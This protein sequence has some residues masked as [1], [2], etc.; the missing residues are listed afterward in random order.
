MNEPLSISSGRNLELTKQGREVF[1]RPRLL[2][3]TWT[4][5][6]E[7]SNQI[8]GVGPRQHV[9][10]ACLQLSKRLDPAAAIIACQP[11]FKCHYTIVVVDLRGI[12][13]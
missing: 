2:F 6:S 4:K 3:G 1:N 8:V 7:N 13:L 11:I 9:W 5:P 12:H 10:L